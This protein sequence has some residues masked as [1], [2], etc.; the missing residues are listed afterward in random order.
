MIVGIYILFFHI[1]F[2][3]DASAL[4]WGDRFQGDVSQ[5]LLNRLHSAHGLACQETPVG[6]VLVN[7]GVSPDRRRKHS[8]AGVFDKLFAPGKSILAPAFDV[9]QTFDA[10]LEFAFLHGVA[11]SGGCKTLLSVP[12]IYEFDDAIGWWAEP[13]SGSSI[14]GW[15]YHPVSILVMLWNPHTNTIE[16][17]WPSSCGN[18][19]CPM[20]LQVASFYRFYCF[21]LLVICFLCLVMICLVLLVTLFFFFDSSIV[22]KF[23]IFF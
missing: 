16:H 1:F 2:Q 7:I 8:Y 22:C 5:G 3:F 6:G 20:V 4:S 9:T 17:A 13:A 11:P 14:S 23:I 21:Y 19:L 18:C 15:V 12:V 10:L